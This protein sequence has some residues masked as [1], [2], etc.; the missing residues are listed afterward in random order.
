MKYLTYSL[1][2]WVGMESRHQRLNNFNSKSKSSCTVLSHSRCKTEV[3]C[4]NVQILDYVNVGPE[5]YR[6]GV[7]AIINK[8]F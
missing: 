7:L 8:Q 3:Y 2:H 1:Y 4:K 6:S 5:L